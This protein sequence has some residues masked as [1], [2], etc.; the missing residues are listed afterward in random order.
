M[1]GAPD[2]GLIVVAV[3]GP[4]FVSARVARLLSPLAEDEGWEVTLQQPDELDGYEDLIVVVDGN[5]PDFPAAPD[6]TAPVLWLVPPGEALPDLAAFVRD[7][8]GILTDDASTKEIFA[9]C[10]ALLAGLAV[11]SP[12]HV[13]AAPEPLPALTAAEQA[14]YDGVRAGQSNREV[15]E[16]LGITVNTV[17]FH[18]T[19]IYQK[20]GVH[21]RTAAAARSS[22][23]VLL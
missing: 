11:V 18:L 4:A 2:D 3:V 5:P 10:R 22:G 17:K 14:V 8:N 23:D 9:A 19:S 13:T 7:G 15:G 1:V 12:A 6:G 21:N 16:A 20:L